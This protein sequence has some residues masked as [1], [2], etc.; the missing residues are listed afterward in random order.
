MYFHPCRIQ[1]GEVG[2]LIFALV[3]LMT[4]GVLDLMLEAA[5][6]EEERM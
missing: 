6:E 4:L 5:A 3:L 2:I 1:C